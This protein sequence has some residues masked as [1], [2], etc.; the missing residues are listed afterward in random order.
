MNARLV[1]IFTHVC[2]RP[3]SS[4]YRPG[5]RKGAAE[6]VRSCSDRS[7]TAGEDIIDGYSRHKIK[8]EFHL[9]CMLSSHPWP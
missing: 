9:G 6:D 1:F 8:T 7:T 2:A 3:N 4:V 5:H